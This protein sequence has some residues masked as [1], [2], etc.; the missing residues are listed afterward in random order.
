MTEALSTKILDGI[1][2]ELNKYIN[3]ENNYVEITADDLQ[4]IVL[5]HAPKEKPKRPKNAFFFWMDTLKKDD[6]V[7]EYGD[8]TSGRGGLKRLCG[9]LWKEMGHDHP[10]KLKFTDMAEVAKQ[11]YAKAMEEFKTDEVVSDGSSDDKP[12][13][14]RGRK[15]KTNDSKKR[16][17]NKK[18]TTTPPQPVDPPV[19]DS[20]ED[21]EMEVD[22][23]EYCG[24]TYLLDKSTG[25]L[26]PEDAESTDVPPI[27]KKKGSKV[28]IF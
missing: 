26:Y 15:P 1:R 11:D 9:R 12:K 24:V 10:D 7:A 13:K 20:Q 2:A 27:G 21:E 14:T 6:L 3:T 28:V 5:R 8:E 19:A 4:E 17:R 16:G 22:E 25:N 23:F 18:N